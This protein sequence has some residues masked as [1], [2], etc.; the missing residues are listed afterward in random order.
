MN[1]EKVRVWFCNLRS[2][3]HRIMANYLKRRNWVV[4][5]LEPRSR[6]CRG[7]CWLEIYEQGEKR[8]NDN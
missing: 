7:S 2:F 5:Y 4:F 6:T 8:K 3:H 1:H